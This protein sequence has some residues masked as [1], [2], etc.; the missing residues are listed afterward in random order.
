MKI[1]TNISDY[2]DFDKIDEPFLKKLIKSKF[3]KIKK[4][5]YIN[6]DQKLIRAFGMYNSVYLYNFKRYSRFWTEDF[7]EEVEKHKGDFHR[8]TL[9]YGFLY[10]AFHDKR[11]SKV[12]TKN[13]GISKHYSDLKKEYPYA[14]LFHLLS[15]ELQHAQQSES[16]IQYKMDNW[17]EYHYLKEQ[18]CN[19]DIE[20][21]AEV[22]AIKK[23]PKMFRSFYG[24]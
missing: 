7:V 21:D 1:T 14:Y 20:F 2:L 19:S 13:W 6:I 11:I 15:H 18:K 23:G 16:T 3:S 12:E 4:P 24:V 17:P 22:A 8:V 10:N 5:V 9:S